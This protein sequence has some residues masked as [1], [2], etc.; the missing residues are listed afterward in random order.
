MLPVSVYL[1]RQIVSV[2]VAVDI[3]GL[4]GASDP[5]VDGEMDYIIVILSTDCTGLVRRTVVDDDI[6]EFRCVILYIFHGFFYICFFVERGNNNKFS[7]I[8]FLHPD[9]LGCCF[10]IF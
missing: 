5:Q 8:V 4:N 7:G 6:I 1:Y 2:S 9:L 3:S 10:L